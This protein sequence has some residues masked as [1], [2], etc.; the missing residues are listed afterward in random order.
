MSVPA[1]FQP[2][3]IRGVTFRNRIWLSPLCEYS[4]GQDGVPTD[5]HLVHLGSCAI[6]RVGLV[7]AEAT[8]INPV[9]RISPHDVGIWNDEQVTGWKRVT[10][11]IHSQGVAAG[12]QLAHAGRKGSTAPGWGVDYENSATPEQGGW[13]TVAPS[14]IA[15]GPFDVPVA[16]DLAGIDAVVA[17]WADAARRAVAAGFDVVEVHA[18]HGYLIHQFLSPLTNERTDEYG[19][20][21]ENR[22]RLVRRVVRAVRE[23]IG[24][25]VPL[26]VRLSATDWDERGITVDDVAT[27]AGWVHEDGADLIDTSTGGIAPESPSRSDRATR[28]RSR[29]RFDGPQK[30][31]PMRWGRSRAPNRRMRSSN[32]VRRTPSCSVAN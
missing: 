10:D 11:F 24:D 15:F 19:G 23:A 18:A 6:G 4:A 20:S 9:A 29:T 26:F 27:V 28:S 25:A 3:T 7:M 13:Q 14:A 30:Y 16:L 17:D 21:L 32:P 5:W 1:L 8:G 12:I 2:L 31:R 22:A